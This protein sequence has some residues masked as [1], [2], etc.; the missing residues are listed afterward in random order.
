MS[1]PVPRHR[2]A[3]GLIVAFAV[4]SLGG[5]TPEIVPVRVPASR[6]ATWFP[7]GTNIRVLTPERFEELTKAI[8]ASRGQPG[9]PRVIKAMHSARWAAGSLS[10]RSEWTIDRSRATEPSGLISLEPWSPALVGSPGSRRW[11]R[12][13][14]EG[15]L[16]LQVD[17]TTPA[18]LAFDW[19]LRATEGSHG[20]VFD[21]ELPEIAISGLSLDLPAGMV[22]EADSG[23]RVAPSPGSPAGRTTWKFEGARGRLRLKLGTPGDLADRPDGPTNWLEGPTRIDL[24]ATS[25]NWIG[26]WR[27][28][29]SPGAPDRLA[30]DLDP[31][32]DLIDLAGPRVTSFRVEGRPPGSRVLVELSPPGPEPATAFVVRAQCR[33]PAEGTWTI[34]G[35]RPSGAIWTAGRVSVRVD[36]SRILQDCIE[37]SGRR[38]LGGDDQPGGASALVFEPLRVDGPIADLSFRMP[39]ADAAVAIRGCFRIGPDRPSIDVALTWTVDR[40]PLLMHDVDLA[41]GWEPDRVVS[42]EGEPV[43]WHAEVLSRGGIRV[44]A[45]PAAID[46]EGRAS[47]L[48]LSASRDR[49]GPGG[50]IDLPRVRPA[51]GSGKAIEEIW[52]TP[53]VPGFSVRPIQ[54]RGLAWIDPPTSPSTPDRPVPWPADG[55]MGALAWRWIG[56]ESEGRV[57]RRQIQPGPRIRVGLDAK[58]AG[59]RLGLDGSI[60]IEPDGSG[61]GSLP[62]HLD[63]DVA[64]APDWHPV[65]PAGPG[66]EVRPLTPAE[67]LAAGFPARGSAW[68]LAFSSAPARAFAIAGRIETPWS[69]TGPIPL[70]TVPARF[71]PAGLLAVEVEEADLCRLDVV[72]LARIDRAGTR[73][74]P[75]PGAESSPAE[76]GPRLRRVGL[77]EYGPEGGKVVATTETRP[78]GVAGGLVREATLVSQVFDGSGHRHRLVLDIHPDAARSV[79]LSLPAGLILDRARRDGQPVAP[80]PLGRAIRIDLPSP[81]LARPSSLLTIDYRIQDGAEAAPLRL[82]SILPGCSMPCVSFVWEVSTPR[83]WDVRDESDDLVASDPNADRPWLER[84]LGTARIGRPADRGASEVIDRE[85]ALRDLERFAEQVKDGGESL[86]DWFLRLDAGRRPLVIDRLSL[87]AAGLGPGTLRASPTTTARPGTPVVAALAALDLEAVPVGPAILITTTEGATE[88][89]RAGSMG[90]GRWLDRVRRAVAEGTDGSD[91]FQSADRWRGET[92]PRAPQA[93]EGPDRTRAGAGWQVSRF[94]STGWP[95]GSGRLVVADRAAGKVRGWLLTLLI[96]VVAG[97]AGDRPWRGRGIGLAMT[98]AIAATGFSATWP[99]PSATA[100]GL[101][102]G[103]LGALGFW[104]LRATWLGRRPVGWGTFVSRLPGWRSRSVPGALLALVAGIGLAGPGLAEGPGADRP[105]LALFPEPDGSAASP[106]SPRVLMRLEDHDRLVALGEATRPTPGDRAL[107]ISAQHRI[108]REGRDM[109]TVVSRYQVE[110]AGGGDGPAAWAMPMG[111][112]LDLSA[113]VDDRPVPLAID[114]AAGLASVSLPGPGPHSVEFRRGVRIEPSGIEGERVRVAINRAAFARASI[115]RDPKSRPAELPGAAGQVDVRGDRVEGLIGPLA[116][117]EARWQLDGSPVREPTP[118]NVEASVLWDALPLGDLA[119]VRLVHS[120]PLPL[121]SIEIEVEPGVL[122]RRL[123]V[124]GSSTVRLAGTPDHPAWI[125]RADPPLPR[126]VPFELELWRGLTNLGGPR[127]LPG[128]RLG[129]AGHLAGAVGLR[130]P[131]GWSGRLAAEGDAD[132][133]EG[134]AFQA[135]WADAIGTGLVW[136]G[137]AP[138]DQ[139]N[140]P[141]PTISP[142]ILRRS[143]QGRLACELGPGRLVATLE[144]TL[145]DLEGR[146]FAVELGFPTDFRITLVRADGLADWR[147]SARDRIRLQF[148]GSIARD[149]RIRLEGFVPAPA[150]SAL[151]ES[152]SFLARIPWPRWFGVDAEAGAADAVLPQP[153]LLR[154]GDPRRDPPDAR[155]RLGPGLP[156]LVPGRSARGAGPGPVDIADRRW[157]A[158]RSGAS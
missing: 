94:T 81:T 90:R 145:S 49:P 95:D 30:I 9:P 45:S 151:T 152:R 21:L 82:G 124:P 34:P 130:K 98:L 20:Q 139:A 129:G 79:E 60:A 147:R 148:D 118:G 136:A 15:R 85:A 114:V 125:V 56:D 121:A 80:I 44:H 89:A 127:V 104:S 88:P 1:R 62:V 143:V 13:S 63:A 16:G 5:S 47:S 153:V 2:L 133:A 93:G 107:A 113:T 115:G 67:R 102:R 128:F 70:L 138:F 103:A 134:R 110:V 42:A 74:G 86:G 27:L 58:I 120:G 54:G 53:R 51:P 36:P 149:R 68:N 14:A 17:A 111:R 22:P 131:P 106:A 96:V 32:L 38:V 37:R 87:Q 75:E 154:A 31:G 97:L 141:A 78:P 91:R 144:A 28:A 12:S 23:T 61:L 41:P 57:E 69:G 24:G 122:V 48:I 140:R 157:W 156:G 35:A 135:R 100:Q 6:V 137:S 117:L 72:G 26:E 158:S 59:S 123:A 92:T 76:A 119:R 55:L 50:S 29:S 71:R 10:G 33:A 66:V 155:A 7:A 109:A 108:D 3:A 116:T 52:V 4:A 84:L 8:R 40:G 46:T 105:I 126:G 146:S 142:P 19:Q 65:D 64:T 18:S 150:D 83:S 73:P 43:P 101:L 99:E 132:P 77:F 25:A 11:A 39:S 112:S